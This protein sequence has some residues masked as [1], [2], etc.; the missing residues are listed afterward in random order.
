MLWG[1]ISFYGV[2]IQ[3]FTEGKHNALMYT[4]TLK[5]GLLPVAAEV[6]REQRTTWVFKQDNAPIHTARTANLGVSIG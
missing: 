1:C 5:C 3:V 4:E 6:F 2:E